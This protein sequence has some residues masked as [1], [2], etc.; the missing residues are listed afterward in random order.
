MPLQ[1][2]LPKRGF[3]PVRKVEFQEVNIRDLERC[4]G[5]VEFNPEVMK[6]M[7]LVKSQRRPVKVLGD[8]TIDR[9]IQVRAHAFSLAA[10][11]KIRDAGGEVEVI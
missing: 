5:A 8:G 2:R 9:K 4:R 10:A 6:E 7:G 1:R 3:R 11:K